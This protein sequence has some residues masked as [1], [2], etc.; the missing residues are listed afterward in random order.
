MLICKTGCN[1]PSEGT[2]T[3]DS[4]RGFLRDTLGACSVVSSMLGGAVLR[5]AQVR[6]R[7]ALEAGTLFDIEK[8]AE[9]VYA[10]VASPVA[11]ENC[12]A[13]IFENF[14][15][16]LIVDAHSKPS[17]VA[18]LVSQIRKEITNKPVRY[19]VI[20]HLDNDHARGTPGYRKIEPKVDIVASGA[21][22]R[23]LL[24]ENESGRFK[25]SVEKLREVVETYRE[26]AAAAKSGSERTYYQRLT[27]ETGEYVA[28]MQTYLP[29][30]ALPNVTFERH[31]VIHDKA[32]D[33]HIAFCGRGHTAGDVVVYCPQKKVIATGDLLHGYMPWLP[34]AY[35]L[36]WPRT[37]LR[38]AAFD[39]EHVVGGHGDVQHT[40]ERLYQWA[41]YIEELTELVMTRGTKTVQQLIEGT[42]PDMLKSLRG[43]FAEFF[44]GQRLKYKDLPPGTNE[45]D[46]LREVVKT[47][48]AQIAR[49]PPEAF[50]VSDSG[51][52]N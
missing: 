32:H 4:R 24:A 8:V 19:V 47:S 48:I 21:T 42:R 25:P 26:K 2:V 46:L 27:E 17:A 3:R 37:L 51:P 36:E 35:P 39:F 33:L 5:A 22:R 13:V 23:L 28:E 15:D 14:A 52:A 11:V 40:R 30:V 9:G 12:N 34:R 10:A 16:L 29:E 45:A 7:S 6:A 31:L 49:R 43:G 18:S 41:A 50:E 20:T 44:I 38:V 1:Y